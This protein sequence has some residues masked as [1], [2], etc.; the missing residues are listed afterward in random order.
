M[1]FFQPTLASTSVRHPWYGIRTRSNQERIVATFLEGKGFEPYLPIYRVCKR[2]SDRRIEK[3][4][5]LFAGY[6]FCRFEA[7]Q[8]LPILTTP[9][10][11]SVVGFGSEPVPIPD[12][13]IE[14]IQAIL[15]S[16]FPAEPCHYFHE[17]QRVR[18]THG[19]LEGLQ[20]ILVRR[21]S[22]W[23][24]VVSVTTL[25]RSISVEIDRD[26]LATVP[27]NTATRPSPTAVPHFKLAS[28]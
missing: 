18:I 6:V 26:C 4:V 14:A 20:G 1:Q 25:Q 19:A 21:K 11:V 22:E 13:E 2:W 8:R 9:G 3:D 15:A 16:G 5:P 7:R 17:G 12:A 23:R 24:V 28:A 27:P 10:V